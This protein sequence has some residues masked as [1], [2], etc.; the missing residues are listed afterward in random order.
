ME[1][2][3]SGIEG[4][5][6]SYLM[7]LR[8]LVEEQVPFNVSTSRGFE[9][10]SEAIS[11][12]GVGSLSASTLKRVWGYVRDTPGKHTSTLDVLAKFAGFPNGIEEFSAYCDRQTESESGFGKARVLDMSALPA[13]SLVEVAWMPD[14][15][16]VM[17]HDGDCV[18]EI[19]EVENAK[20]TEGMKVKCGR[21]VDGRSLMFDLLGG[22]DKSPLVYEAGK[23]HGITWR[24]F[25]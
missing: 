25:D 24:I 5:P 7:R 9:L 20:L 13:G 19:M 14:R 16:I 23:V 4:L 10:L 15:R 3:Q 11:D 21:L 18:F 2:L 8:Q 22:S 12:S 1:N 17:R 6:A